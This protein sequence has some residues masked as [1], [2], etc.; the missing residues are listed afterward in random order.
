MDTVPLGQV[1]EASVSPEPQASVQ[2]LFSAPKDGITKQKIAV[3]YN[4][5]LSYPV[6][7]LLVRRKFAH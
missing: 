1:I 2:L 4:N 6:R 7:H 5:L 3:S